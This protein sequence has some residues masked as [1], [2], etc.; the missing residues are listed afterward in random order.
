MK[1]VYMRA[2]AVVLLFT[3]AVVSG[4][5]YNAA[6]A[7]P[8]SQ[9]DFQIVPGVRMGSIRT[10]VTLAEAVR[11]ATAQFG[12]MDSDRCNAQDVGVCV[13]EHGYFG[14]ETPGKVFTV[15]TDDPRFKTAKGVHVG[16]EGRALVEEFGDPSD[17]FPRPDVGVFVVHWRHLGIGATVMIYGPNQGKIK[18]IAVYQLPKI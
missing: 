7:A 10:G 15:I 6:Q 14:E 1:P 16:G 18:A 17:S 2:L 9:G 13:S 11:V 12:P 5:V 4:P 3:F 8:A